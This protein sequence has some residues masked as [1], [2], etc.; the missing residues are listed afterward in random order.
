MKPELVPLAEAAV[1]T[2]TSRKGI[3]RRLRR[4]NTPRYLDPKNHRRYLVD[5][6]DLE[7]FITPRV[8]PSSTRTE[9]VVDAAA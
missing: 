5:R 8:I 3:E 4:H 7:A 6:R 2:G 9:Q 1:I